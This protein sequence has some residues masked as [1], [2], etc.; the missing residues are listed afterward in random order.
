MDFEQNNNLKAGKKE[1]DLIKYNL[2]YR[3]RCPDYFN[4][5]TFFEIKKN[6]RPSSASLCWQR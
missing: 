1:R 5:F 2:W 6:E 3:L 4:G